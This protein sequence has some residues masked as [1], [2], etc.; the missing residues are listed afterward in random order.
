MVKKKDPSSNSAVPKK[1]RHQWTLPVANRCW[2]LAVSTG[3]MSF[4]PALL[5]RI[6]FSISETFYRVS[7]MYLNSVIVTKG[8]E[9]FR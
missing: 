8:L 7:H 9:T 3:L 1:G 2:E 6:Y 5:G 4:L